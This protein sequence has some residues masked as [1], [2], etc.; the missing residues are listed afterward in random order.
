MD[1]KTPIMNLFRNRRE[2]SRKRLVTELE[3]RTESLTKKDIHHWR[4]A[5]Q[6]A[7]NVENPNRSRLYSVYDDCMID[8][9]LTGAVTQRKGINLCKVFKL[10]DNT[11]KEDVKA[12]ELFERQWFADFLDMALDSIYWGHSLVEMGDVIDDGT[13]L[14]YSDIELIPRRH[15]VPEYGVFKINADDDPKKGISYRMGE[16]SSGVVEIGKKNDLGLLLKCAPACISKKN[17]LAFWDVFGEIF[18]MPI[19]IA[20]T[21]TTDFDERR[22]I[23]DSLKGQGAG[24]WSVVSEGTDIQILGND[25]SDAY[26]VY[27]RRI[28]R[29]NS[30]ISKAILGQ[31]MT[32]DNGSSHSQSE[33]HLE[34]LKNITS[35]DAKMLSYVVNDRLIPMMIRDGFPIKGLRFAWDD[36]MILTPEQWVGVETLLLQHYDIDP[37]YFIDRYNVNITGI[38]ER[39]LL[40]KETTRPQTSFFE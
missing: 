22:R 12:T 35:Q 23:E 21:S 39:Q 10:V 37:E 40:S 33:V 32:I 27:D 14:R 4:Q 38:K 17:M 7:L 15:V 1:I 24:F 18:G 26:N 19:R 28:D 31:T 6:M 3:R 8:N 16:Y 5:H 25:R 20:R 29:A 13:A 2:E 9:H 36:A 30:E 11:G 34:V